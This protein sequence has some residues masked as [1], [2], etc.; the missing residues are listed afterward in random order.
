MKILLLLFLLFS[1][2]TY[3]EENYP[4][5]YFSPEDHLDQKLIELI[6]GE[7]KSIRAAIYCFTSRDI[8]EA[9]IRAKKRGVQ[10]E[11]IADPFSFRPR[12]QIGKIS[13]L[14][15]KVFLFDAKKV[16]GKKNQDVIMH[17]KF[18]LFGENQEG[19]SLVWTGSFNFTLSAA[20]YNR[21]NAIILADPSIYERYSQEFERLKKISCK[22]YK[23]FL[24]A[25]KK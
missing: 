19:K 16:E 12:C 10:L 25:Q 17:H 24:A 8:S 14:G 5:A 4:Q 13:R 21:E 15:G 23:E 11:V 22:S 1:Q 3:C 7:K 9:L 2:L 20:H 18:C 6:D